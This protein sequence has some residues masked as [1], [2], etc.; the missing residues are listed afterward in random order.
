MNSEQQ[1]ELIQ[2]LGRAYPD[3]KSE[4]NFANNYQLLVAVLLSAQCTDKKVNQVTPQFFQLYPGFEDLAK[5]Q[6]SDIEE[7]IR[8]INYYK[9]KSKNLLNLARDIV[10]RHCGQVPLTF[11]SL[12]DLPGVGQ[13][14]ANVVLSETGTAFT[15]PVDT[16]V[17]R[18]SHRLGLANGKTPE[19]VEDQLKQRFE[20]TLWRNLHHW[21]ILHG[22]RVC[23]AQTPQC[24]EC[25]LRAICPKLVVHN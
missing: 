15:F 23:K 12:I 22:R 3:P 20:P 16:H 6:I 4:L 10:E 1:N 21:L 11:E 8:P 9:T 5:A 18:L 24:L 7:I 25:D 19:L 14:T 2:I 17:F 13:K